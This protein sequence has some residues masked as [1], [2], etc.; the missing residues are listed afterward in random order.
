M[1]NWITY[2]SAVRIICYVI[3]NLFLKAHE[4]ENH[5][6]LYMRH[7]DIGKSSHRW[8]QMLCGERTLH[9]ATVYL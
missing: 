6:A 3:H 4:C 2:K 5:S 8:S 9:V 7:T 1:L